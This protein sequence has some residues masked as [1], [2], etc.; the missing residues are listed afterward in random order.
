MVSVQLDQIEHSSISAACGPVLMM[1]EQ[2]TSPSGMQLAESEQSFRVTES[3]GLS[4]RKRL[5]Q[6]RT[7]LTK[8]KM[9]ELENFVLVCPG[10]LGVVGGGLVESLTKPPITTT[11]HPCLH[12]SSRSCK[13]TR[14][15]LANGLKP[16]ITG[17]HQPLIELHQALYLRA[18]V[19]SPTKGK[20]LSIAAKFRS[21][22]KLTQFGKWAIGKKTK[23]VHCCTKQLS[24]PTITAMRN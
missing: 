3:G 4:S 19:S 9:A 15:A 10:V 11:Y 23:Q 7:R 13:N 2:R 14:L 16:V 12:D 1:N 17:F 8:S 20:H 22:K 24:K 18:N 5:V 21:R 6:S